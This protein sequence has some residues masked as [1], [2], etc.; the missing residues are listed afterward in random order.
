[1]L[2]RCKYWMILIIF[3]VNT[4]EFAHF[5]FKSVELTKGGGDCLCLLSPGDFRVERFVTNNVGERLPCNCCGPHVARIHT[6][7][8]H[9]TVPFKVQ[10]MFLF[11]CWLHSEEAFYFCIVFY[12]QR[13]KANRPPKILPP[14]RTSLFG[15]FTV[16]NQIDTRIKGTVI[17]RQTICRE[18]LIRN[19]RYWKRPKFT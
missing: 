12:C 17:R 3:I 18:F 16:E 5:F 9:V 19:V 14:V 1:M 7:F 6:H 10:I 13:C 8:G 4:S 2:K 15:Y 11:C